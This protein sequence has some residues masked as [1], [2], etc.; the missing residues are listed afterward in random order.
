ML[1]THFT[2][3]H[4]ATLRHTLHHG[5]LAATLLR[6]AETDFT[7]EVIGQWVFFLKG[8]SQHSLVSHNDIFSSS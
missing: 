6:D 5:R 4:V 7:V 1:R 2:L 3:W 8:G